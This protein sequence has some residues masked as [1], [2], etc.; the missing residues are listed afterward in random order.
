MENGEKILWSMSLGV[1]VLRIVFRT[2]LPQETPIWMARWMP[3]N[4][5]TVSQF[6]IPTKRSPYRALYRKISLRFW[7]I[8]NYRTS[9]LFWGGGGWG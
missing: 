2:V 6:K 8:S 5:G 1:S 3:Q 9:S 7:D 4:L